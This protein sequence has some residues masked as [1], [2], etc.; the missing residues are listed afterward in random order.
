MNEIKQIYQE[1]KAL[2]R[3]HSKISLYKKFRIKQ[4]NKKL[5]RIEAPRTSL[6]LIQKELLS[7][8]AQPLAEYITGVGGKSI[9]DN[10]E[11]HKN[12]RWIINIDIKD[13][14][15]SVKLEKLLPILIDMYGKEGLAIWEMGNLEG[16]LPVGAPTSPYL[17]NLA[18][19]VLDKV[20]VAKLPRDVRYS[21]Y[22]D[23]ISVS[24]TRRTP[25]KDV[26]TLKRDILKLIRASFYRVQSAKV[27]VFFKKRDRQKVTGI[28]VSSE[29]PRLDRE[30][31][32]KFRSGLD[33][34]ARL[35]KG[36]TDRASGI[37]AFTKMVD[38][39]Q[40]KRL[41]IYFKKRLAFYDQQTS[42]CPQFK[43]ASS[44]SNINQKSG[45]PNFY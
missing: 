26:L 28:S 32:K 13:F 23:D 30:R 36:L 34:E 12:A 45:L 35:H 33:H 37:L 7:V 15:H 5:R 9:S 22:I 39:E 4:A 24:S 25:A 19:T 2:K 21:R 38:R 1:Y 3:R 20:I 40:W 17:A 27:G 8:I 44:Q 6:K 14:F 10:A 18:G 16:R 41:K 42:S 11:I 29:K 31:Y 43:D